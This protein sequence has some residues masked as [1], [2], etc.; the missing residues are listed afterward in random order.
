MPWDFTNVQ[1][2]LPILSAQVRQLYDGL[3]GAISD[4]PIT[5]AGIVRLQNLFG[6]DGN[7]LASD[8]AAPGAGIARLYPKADGWYFRVGAAGAVTPLAVPADGSI[9]PV[10]LNATGAAANTVPLLTGTNTWIFGGITGAYFA[11]GSGMVKLGQAELTGSASSISFTSIPATYKNLLLLVTA[12][13]IAGAATDTLLLRLNNDT[14]AN[15][16]WITL[17]AINTTVSASNVIGASSMQVGTIVGSS[18]TVA[19]ASEYAIILPGYSHS[20]G[21]QHGVISEG[22]ARDASAAASMS[23]RRFHGWWRNAAAINRIDIFPGTGPNFIAD[24]LAYLY[25]IPT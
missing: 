6:L 5:P 2:G 23:I 8:P 22:G 17:Q 9:L 12:R 19:F 14:G 16:D 7:V 13:S 18:G 4:Q 15:Y 3:T 24:T 21:F 25:G 20:S 1:P 11:S 10:K